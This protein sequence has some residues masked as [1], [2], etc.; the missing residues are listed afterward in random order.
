MAV[1]ARAVADGEVGD[2]DLQHANVPEIGAILTRASPPFV[3]RH[4]AAGVSDPWPV[5]GSPEWLEQAR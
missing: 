2:T 5:K 3:H 4:F 1:A